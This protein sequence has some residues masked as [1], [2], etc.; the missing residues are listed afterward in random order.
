M[1][2]S[3]KTA[4]GRKSAAG[5]KNIASGGHAGVS[6]EIGI[7]KKVRE[8]AKLVKLGKERGY[9]S[10]DE[11][12]SNLPDTVL[13]SA[14]AIEEVYALFDANNIELID[15]ETRDDL[16]RR[17]E[18]AR[19]ARAKAGENK[20]ASGVL[21]EKTN[22]PVRMYLREMG[23]VPLLTRAGEV[24]IARRI[25]CGERTVMNALADS[26]FVL[27]ELKLLGDRIRKGQV[28]ASLFSFSGTGEEESS[29]IPLLKL[30]NAKRVITRIKRLT[31]AIEQSPAPSGPW[32]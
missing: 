15:A 10:L 4:A 17:P 11:I 32:K 26:P 16:I 18:Q 23:T 21:L 25:E 2:K 24:K 6:A 31:T 7:E 22:D 5:G 14:S 28:S 27:E 8:V 3:T 29:E 13:G 9:V 12:N 1:G 19:A 20:S 30:A